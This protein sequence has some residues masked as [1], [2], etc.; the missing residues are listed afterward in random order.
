MTNSATN[1]GRWQFSILDLMAFT[2]MVALVLA[3]HRLS[4]GVLLD[5]I[6][7]E[8]ETVSRI[9]S[10]IYLPDLFLLPVSVALLLWSCYMSRCRCDATGALALLVIAWLLITFNATNAMMNSLMVIGCGTTIISK[11][12][13]INLI[14]YGTV[15]LPLFATMPAIYCL[16]GRFKCPAYQKAILYSS[17]LFAVVDMLLLFYLV[18]STVGIFGP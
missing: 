4:A 14:L 6:S 2:T 1:S 7:L 8:D 16:W 3:W 13:Q 5:R 9:L 18:S 11:Q 17:A 10:M 12:F 15:S